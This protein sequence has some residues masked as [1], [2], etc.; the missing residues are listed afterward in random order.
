MTYAIL[1]LTNARIEQG[2]S[3]IE[4]CISEALSISES[5]VTV[6]L[7][8]DDSTATIILY[9]KDENDVSAPVDADLMSSQ[10]NRLIQSG[11]AAAWANIDSKCAQAED[12][13]E[14]SLEEDAAY[15]LWQNIPDEERTFH[16]DKLPNP[17][18][19]MILPSH[20]STDGNAENTGTDFS[21]YQAQ[22]RRDPSLMSFDNVE[23]IDV[24]DIHM[25]SWDKPAIITNAVPETFANDL[26][27]KDR[28]KDVY[29]NAQVRT[30]NRETLIDNGFNNS[31]PMSLSEAFDTYQS[32]LAQTE[33]GTIVFSPVKELPNQFRTELNPLMNAFPCTNEAIPDAKKFTL[34]IASTGFGIGMHKHNAAMFMLLVGKKKWYMS[35]SED[36]EGVANTH[37]E[38]Y[39]DLSSHK[40]IQQAGE[41]LFVPNEWYH[42]IFNLEYTLGIQALPE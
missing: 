42:E 15:E 37:P 7:D 9:P 5:K 2:A 39:R 35:A 33:C 36:L 6:M 3:L 40:C 30:G 22:L 4:R 17:D 34:T 26:L 14:V 25:L 13:E 23:R 27:D 41:V 21:P 20:C 10:L 8:D 24:A 31:K 19:V 38:F 11:E 29:G 28:L 1:T 12:E 18:G 32:S 16:L